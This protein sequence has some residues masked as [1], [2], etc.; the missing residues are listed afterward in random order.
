MMNFYN[1]Y[2]I[3]DMVVYFNLTQI[4]MIIFLFDKKKY[5]F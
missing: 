1:I 4:L 5:F 3:A 2:I